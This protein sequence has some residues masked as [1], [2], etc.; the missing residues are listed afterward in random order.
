MPEENNENE[1][2]IINNLWETDNWSTISAPESVGIP[3]DLVER[4]TEEGR[5]IRDEAI[6]RLQ[7]NRRR[8]NVS[9]QVLDTI[10]IELESIALSRET[11]G[12]ILG[13][14]PGGLGSNFKVTRDGSSEMNVYSVPINNRSIMINAH[15]RGAEE[16]LNEKYNKTTV[17]YELISVPMDIDVAEKTLH[18]LLPSLECNGDF[19]SERC[20]THIHIGAMKNIRF[21]K[22]ALKLGLWFDEVFYSLSPMGQDKFR[23]YSNNAIYARPLLSGPY[24]KY[25]RDYYQILNFKRALESDD[26]Y[27]FFA[28][29]GTT[30]ID[31][32]LHKYHPGRY[33]SINL[34]S[35]PR[36]GTIEFRHFNQSFNPGLVSSISKLCQLF[37]EIA[38]KSGDRELKN[39]DVGDVFTLESPSHYL[40]KL[41]KLIDMGNRLDCDYNLG[42]EDIPQLERIIYKYKGIGIQNIPVLTHCRDFGVPTEC[43]NDGELQKAKTK[44]IPAGQVDIHNI[45]YQSIIK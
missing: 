27:E 8:V 1:P 25:E 35:V 7:N 10:G 28:T 20:A 36:I 30:N 23:G 4:I 26:L 16:L 33:F 3:P 31:G 41:Y 2:L 42:K 44:P 18:A 14:L 22:N 21:L 9:G 19:I 40:N 6:L 34:Y 24:F 45:K 13:K 5:R 11:A 29:Y 32:E 12:R 43:I 17:G 15:T 37:T 38:I 39:L